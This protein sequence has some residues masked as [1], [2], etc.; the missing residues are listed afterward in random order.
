MA[1]VGAGEGGAEVE[2]EPSVGGTVNMA[3]IKGL[4]NSK[5]V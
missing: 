1:A 3:E 4:A 5:G 2:N